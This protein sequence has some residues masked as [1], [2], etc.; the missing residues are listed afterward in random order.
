MAS[1]QNANSTAFFTP[2]R[3]A[4]EQVRRMEPSRGR[5]L[6]A[7][8][9]AGTFLARRV[10]ERYKE[11]LAQSGGEDGVLHLQDIDFQFANSETCVRLDRHVGG[12]DVFLLQSL[13]DPTMA[14]PGKHFGIICLTYHQSDVFRH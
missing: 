7:S 10:I 12:Y 5:L 4:Q 13:V 14:P 1:Q 8:C 6:I 11:L 2:E 3:Y 9:R